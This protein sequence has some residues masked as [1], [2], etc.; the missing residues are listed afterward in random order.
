MTETRASGRGRPVRF[1]LLFLLAWSGSRVALHGDFTPFAHRNTP[2]DTR[3]FDTGPF[4]TG[5]AAPERPADKAG[6]PFPAIETAVARPA[7]VLRAASRDRPPARILR[8]RSGGPVQA[9]DATTVDLMAFLPAPRSFAD[10][11]HGDPHI[12]DAVSDHLL[13]APPGTSRVPTDRWRMSSW[14]LWRD[15][16]GP[17]TGYAPPGRLGGS[18]AGVR[19]DTA[20]T[21]VGPGT[22]FA[23]TRVTTALTRPAAPEAALG[24]AVQPTRRVPVS[25]A[26]ERRIALGSGA[27]DAMA[28]IVAGGFGPVAVAT[29]IETEGYAQAGFVGLH[30]MD[31][32]IDGKLSAF[33]LKPTQHLRLGASLSG[34][35]QPG[36]SRLDL[37]PEIQ[38]RL[39]SAPLASRLS[40]EWR[41]RIAGTAAP[42]S[43]LAITLAADF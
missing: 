3:S 32:F 28:V 40:V 9:A 14:I 6:H 12:A 42:S 19:L 17:G 13:S 26:V 23:Y 21:S 10:R 43:G 29:S 36:V 20:L 2:V 30:S 25:L 7:M 22:L 8:N 15:G 34:G 16:S 35:A 31:R 41:A 5:A 33:V 1:L 38:I 24:F 37:G 18:Q 11:H 39:P 27:R 4:D